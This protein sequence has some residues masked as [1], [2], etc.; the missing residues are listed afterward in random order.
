MGKLH[1]WSGARGQSREGCAEAAHM[2]AGQVLDLENR[3]EHLWNT[4]K[5][6]K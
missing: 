6:F 3:T 5:W 1:R 2:A 4:I